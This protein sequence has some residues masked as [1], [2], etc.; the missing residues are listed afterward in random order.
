MV[1]EVAYVSW[2]N[3]QLFIVKDCN[4]DLVNGTLIDCFGEHSHT[5]INMDKFVKDFIILPKLIYKEG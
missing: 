2:D 4:N 3:D 5:C 1:P